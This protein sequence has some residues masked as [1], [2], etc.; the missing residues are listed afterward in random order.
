MSS[1]AIMLASSFHLETIVEGIETAEQLS[2]VSDL[3]LGAAQG[4]LFGR[5][6]DPAYAARLIADRG[7]P[8]NAGA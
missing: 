6:L 3:G 8:I 5:P 4:F 2:H 1:E 7:W